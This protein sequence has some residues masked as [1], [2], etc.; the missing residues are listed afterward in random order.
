[1]K[2][3][4]KLVI[5]L[6]VSVG[7][8]GSVVTGSQ[9]FS[10]TKKVVKVSYLKTDGFL[11]LD[12]LFKKAK[13]E[14]EKANPNVTIKLNPITGTDSEYTTKLALMHRS[15][16]TQPDV[17]YEDG[18]LVR[19]DVAAGNLL[20]LSKYVKTWSDWSKFDAGAKAA[21]QDDKGKTFAISLGTD[22]RGIFY[23]KSVL[24]EAGISLPWQP[25]SWADFLDTARK[26]H[27]AT[28]KTA[29][30]TY[31][32][33]GAGEGAVM[34]G[35]YMFLYGTGKDPLYDT[36]TGKWVVGSTGFKDALGM[37]NTLFRENLAQPVAEAADGNMWQKVLGPWLK[38]DKDTIAGTIDGSWVPRMWG[39]AG[40]DFEWKT[41]ADEMGV[42]YMPTQKVGGKVSLSGGW[43]IAVG[44]KTKVGTEAFN[45]LK[46]VLNYENA[47]KY[48]T[49]NAQIAVRTDVAKDPAYK[50]ANIFVPFFSSLVSSTHF[51]PATPDYPR[52]S[53]AAQQATDDIM[54]GKK[55]VAEAAAAYDAAVTAIVGKGKVI[56]KP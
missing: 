35:F 44:S 50:S 16:S 1:M 37:Y 4:S 7:L 11:Q 12:S 29:F 30:V 38:T 27:K 28:G 15:A 31:S 53:L 51:R 36:K 23:K 33:N 49:E 52:I 21:G 3:R 13:A 22:T 42:A 5:A 45:F 26:V 43:T 34:Q 32:G 54:N 25:K 48:Y 6:A 39:A 41:Y 14:Y 8:V 55:T 24:K 18:F 20:D 10:A 2:H 9:A 17:F 46:V 47:L 56:K 19:S 40:G